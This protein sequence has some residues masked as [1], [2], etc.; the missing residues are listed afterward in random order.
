MTEQYLEPF[1]L[2]KEAI[3]FDQKSDLQ[4]SHSK[5]A[6]A[7]QKFFDLASSEE[8]I[9]RGLYEYSTLMDAFSRIQ[10]G[11]LGAS[12][13]EFDGALSKFNEASQILRSTIHFGFLA[14]FIAACATTETTD[15]LED[16][17]A[18]KLQGYRNAIAL[19]EQS[20]I[21]LGFRDEHHPI[22]TII[23]A[24][25]RCCISRALALESL[26]QAQS[27]SID[28]AEET[29]K[30]SEL[31]TKEFQLLGSRAGIRTD[32]LIFL[33][34][35]DYRR[36]EEGSYILTYPDKGRLLLLNIGTNPATIDSIGSKTFNERKLES[37]DSLEVLEGEVEKGRIRVTYTDEISGK[38][39][40]EGCVLHV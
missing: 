24:Y 28:L 7:A 23:D 1:L 3:N 16:N 37:R 2:W 21:A 29:K 9:A 22:S 25:I 36:V 19:F 31:I 18:E 15:K 35:D 38:N 17:D 20:K 32:R 13:G 10:L 14:A 11:R 5:F 8:K 30:R 40:D 12:K 26:T 33:P 34:L 27:G 39:Y 6:Q 4:L